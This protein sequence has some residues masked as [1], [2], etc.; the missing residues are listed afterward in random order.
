[1]CGRAGGVCV[2]RVLAARAASH[3]PTATRPRFAP[4]GTHTCT[5]VHVRAR[6]RRKIKREVV[7]KEMQ[8]YAGRSEQSLFKLIERRKVRRND[9]GNSRAHD[10]FDCIGQCT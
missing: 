2:C 9:G 6:T 7:E 8:A 5:R 3:A 4:V 10:A 1:M